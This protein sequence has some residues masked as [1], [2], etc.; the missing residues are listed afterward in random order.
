MEYASGNEEYMSQWERKTPIVKL[1]HV[2]SGQQ[3][4]LEEM[5]H[6]DY[7]NSPSTKN[8]NLSS[9]FDPG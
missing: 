2:H 3:D 5:S 4:Y 9:H 6:Q 1:P 7:Q 8:K